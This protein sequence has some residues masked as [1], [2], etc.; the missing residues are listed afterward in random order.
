MRVRVSRRARSDIRGIL[1]FVG[2][3]EQP[4][5]DRLDAAIAS[6]GQMPNRGLRPAGFEGTPVRAIRVR[7][8]L[9]VYHVDR[10]V[11]VLRVVLGSQDL[12]QLPLR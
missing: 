7:R 1:A 9:V 11:R 8:W 2:M 12:R 4:P 6:L 10:D 3:E 5:A